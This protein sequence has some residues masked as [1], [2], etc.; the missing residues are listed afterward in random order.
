[1]TELILH[2]EATDKAQ[3]AQTAQELEARLSSLADVEEAQ[4]EAAEPK[5][6]GIEVMAAITAA[7]VI[8]NNAKKLINSTGEVVDSTR[9]LTDKVRELVVSIKKLADELGLKASVEVGDKNISLETL[10][11]ADL[12]YMA[13]YQ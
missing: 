12:K 8:T 4:A 3:L 5:F 9:A 2:F 11:E 13:E 6:T 1:M 10:S 7:V